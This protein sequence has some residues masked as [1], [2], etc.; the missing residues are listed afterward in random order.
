MLGGE[1]IKTYQ[2]LLAVGEDD[3]ARMDF[4]RQAINDHQGSDAYKLA[5]DAEQYYEGENPTINNYEKI[6]YDL[7]GK[8]H[9]DMYTANHKIASNF[10]GL[11]V[12]QECSYLLGN[13]VTFENKNTKNRLGNNFDH[14]IM[15]A[16]TNALISGVAFGFGIWITSKF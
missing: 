5:K 3:K 11:A 4:I 2:D 13:G 10:F 14:D 15:D 12:D 9:A 6:L 8:A 1:I 16:G 7:Q